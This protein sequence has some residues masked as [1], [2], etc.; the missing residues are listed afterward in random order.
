MMIT[1]VWY[2]A[3]YQT[4][5]SH[6]DASTSR[7]AI[8]MPDPS[9]GARALDNGLITSDRRAAAPATKSAIQSIYVIALS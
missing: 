5:G 9:A 4:G 1:A 2:D 6:A 8:S 3:P 7:S